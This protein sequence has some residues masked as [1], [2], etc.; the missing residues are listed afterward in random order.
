MISKNLRDNINKV[1]ANRI[2][3]N[4]AYKITLFFVHNDKKIEKGNF[5]FFKTDDIK[6]INIYWLI[7][8]F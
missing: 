8:A 6:Y 4:Y 5:P 2:I 3:T 7:L 1:S